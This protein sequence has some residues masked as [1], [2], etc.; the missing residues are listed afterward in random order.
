M[1]VYRHEGGTTDYLWRQGGTDQAQKQ[2]SGREE[3]GAVFL[4]G[5]GPAYGDFIVGAWLKMLEGS[6]L[7]ED[8]ERV[9]GFQGG[10]WARVVD[11]LKP[12]TEIK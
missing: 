1:K 5:E 7:K 12:W 11:A 2:R 8:W 6:M 9:K 3:E 4:D 10:F